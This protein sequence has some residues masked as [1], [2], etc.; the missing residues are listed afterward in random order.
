MFVSHLGLFENWDTISNF[1]A[2]RFLYCL[3]LFCEG[4]GVVI[5]ALWCKVSKTSA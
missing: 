5:V 4:E 2:S 1:G 3:A